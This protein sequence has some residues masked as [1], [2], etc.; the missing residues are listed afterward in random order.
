[1]KEIQKYL[2]NAIKHKKNHHSEYKNIF[3][4]LS[5]IKIIPIQNKSKQSQI[6]S[7]SRNIQS[8]F[9]SKNISQSIQS[10]NYQWDVYLFSPNYPMG[11]A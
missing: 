6:T 11:Y 4:H 5:S 8:Q 2:F 7:Y 9:M 3:N 1:M 10:F